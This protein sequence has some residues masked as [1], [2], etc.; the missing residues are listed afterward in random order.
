MLY[1]F[2]I[3][4]IQKNIELK[5]YLKFDKIYIKYYERK[6]AKANVYFALHINFAKKL[7]L[8]LDSIKTFEA[9][10]FYKVTCFSAGLF[11]LC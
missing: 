2:N 3:K 11:N 6:N 10:R 1:F 9:R 7:I 4:Q 8:A 5:L